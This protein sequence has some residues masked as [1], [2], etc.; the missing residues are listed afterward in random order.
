MHFLHAPHQTG[1]QHLVGEAMTVPKGKER[2]EVGPR[3]IRGPQVLAQSATDRSKSLGPA[4]KQ[5]TILKQFSLGKLQYSERQGND[6]GVETAGEKTRNQV[7]ARG[8]LDIQLNARRRDLQTFQDSWKKIRGERGD[9]PHGNSKR[10]L[11]EAFPHRLEKQCLVQDP[12][13][14]LMGIAA[15][16]GEKETTTLPLDQPTA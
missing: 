10:S 1:A 15:E 5:K 6:G 7:L 3:Q 8:F 12:E 2:P 9:Y 4:S 11:L 14:L 16:R 13:R